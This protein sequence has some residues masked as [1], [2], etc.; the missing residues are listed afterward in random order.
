MKYLQPLIMLFIVLFLG[1]RLIF[2]DGASEP[3]MRPGPSIY[4]TRTD[5]FRT[6]ED[7]YV[8]VV[9]YTID[10][11]FQAPAF[12]SPEAMMDFMEYLRTIGDVYQREEA[13]E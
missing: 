13:G 12:I 5:H 2:W 10:G 8:W 4:I 7:E 3:K 1:V 11:V 9:E 6:L